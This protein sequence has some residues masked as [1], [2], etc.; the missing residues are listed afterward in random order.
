MTTHTIQVLAIIAEGIAN[1][2]TGELIAVDADGLLD[3]KRPGGYPRPEG[4]KT[5]GN[6]MKA[7][8]TWF[9]AECCGGSIL[10]K[11]TDDGDGGKITI[12]DCPNEDAIVFL[13]DHENGL[14]F[15][16]VGGKC[17]RIGTIGEKSVHWQYGPNAAE[18]RGGV[19]PAYTKKAVVEEV[20][21]LA[22][23][24][25]KGSFK[26]KT[27]TSKPK[28]ETKSKKAPPKRASRPAPKSTKNKAPPARRKG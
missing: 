3:V 11:D 19:H 22:L 12:P 23:N 15:H 5:K 21:R 14:L 7:L 16:Y 4:V 28:G 24:S 13:H 8:G 2:E 6:L 20:C 18:F 26:A 1:A 25:F 10:K 9:L 17:F 27:K